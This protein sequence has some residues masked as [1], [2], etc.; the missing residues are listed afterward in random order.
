MKIAAAEVENFESFANARVEL[1]DINVV[2]GKNNSGK[3][4]FIRALHILQQSGPISNEDMRFG[5]TRGKIAYT[6][7]GENLQRDIFRHFHY[8]PQSNQSS[9]LLTQPFALNQGSISV[10]RA[11]LQTKIDG[12][13][14][15]VGVDRAEAV[16]PN[17]FIYPY[18][19]KRKVAEF[20]EQVNKHHTTTI[21]GDLRFLY[22]RIDR[23]A[24]P[25][26]PGHEEYVALC[27][28][29]LGFRVS[30][31]P[32]EGGKKAGIPVS[33]FDYISIDKMGEGVSNLLGLITDLCVADGNLFLIEEL[34]NDIHPQALKAILDAIVA[35]SANN[36]FVIST[37][38]NIVV[39]HLGAAKNSKVF[40]V[41]LDYTKGQV[42]TST[43]RE[44]RRPADRLELLR[45]LGY[46]LYD[47]DLWEAW[48]MLEESTAEVIIRDYLIPWFAPKLSRVRTL[49]VGGTGKAEATFADFHRLFLFTHLEPQYFKKAWL[50]LDGD[51][52]GK[53]IIGKLQ[54]KYGS[55]PAEHFRTFEKTD[56]ELYYPE[57]FSEQVAEVLSRKHDD[58]PAAK[59]QLVEKVKQWCDESKDEAKA[60][61]EQSASEV[62]DLLKEIET[63][64]AGPKS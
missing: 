43:I 19:S 13:V 41:K 20:N 4:A 63:A 2:V 25:E 35:K 33:R 37:H 24:N 55:W 32:S 50:V 7:V 14:Q 21:A 6:L 51:E 28:Q 5:E 15:D 8:S 27:E 64:L 60:A 12:Q 54:G 61:F 23:L 26:Q 49:S 34:E 3:S 53:M 29:V 42:P 38:S 48:L 1:A 62:I 17:N 39:K 18:L 9:H 11:S 57:K 40:A 56:F 30:A 58:K 22:P 16:E 45:D 47:F 36:Q 59:K 46:E 10:T 44:V 31:N 52:T